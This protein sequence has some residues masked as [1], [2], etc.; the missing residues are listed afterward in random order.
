MRHLAALMLPGILA[1]GSSVIMGDLPS[2]GA[3][4]SGSAVSVTSSGVT[5]GSGA[6]SG[7]VG[8]GGAAGPGCAADVERSLAF[9]SAGFDEITG[10]VVDTSGNIYVAGTSAG[11]VVIDSSLVSGHGGA[12]AF[13]AKL[14]PDLSLLWART[15][16]DALDQGAH[17]LALDPNGGIVVAGDAQGSIDL[18]GGA[19]ASAGD[20]DVFVAKLDVDGEHL[21]SRMFSGQAADWAHG[22]AVDP[23]G[24]V[25][26]GG[27]IGATVDVDG[28]VVSAAAGPGDAFVAKLAADGTPLWAASYGDAAYQGVHS[29]AAFSTG[30]VVITG[31]AAGPVDFGGGAVGPT[32]GGTALDVFVVKL[33]G[34]GS[35]VWTVP[36]VGSGRERAHSVAIDSAD[37]VVT[38]GQFTGTASFAGLD[39]TSAGADDVYL[40]KLDA[41]GTLVWGQ[42]H[43]DSSIDNIRQVTVGAD[44]DV[45]LAGPVSGSTDL[46]CG[47]V[48]GEDGDPMGFVRRL[49]ASGAHRLTHL[50]GDPSSDQPPYAMQY[51]QRAAAVAGGRLVVIGNFHFAVQLASQTHTSQGELDTFV[52]VLVEPL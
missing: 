45:L 15:Y 20:R 37:R 27:S 41:A 50:F 47:P 26:V 51:G 38:T 21:W 13:V 7:S 8:S 11:N 1:C 52:A 40:V 19:L 9:G 10:L 35:H 48:G 49:D 5:S 4:G 14:G 2:A 39:L 16:G 23:A 32:S 24:N 22:V 31:D 42:R 44:D 29:I 30:D 25:F 3:G 12:D 33:S 17:G 34:N 6:A 28:I 36:F 43:G 18:G 46:G